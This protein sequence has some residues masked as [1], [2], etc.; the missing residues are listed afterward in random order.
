M[1]SPVWSTTAGLLAVINEREFYSQTLTATDADGDTLTYSKIAGTL[2][3]GIELTSGG[4]L[5]GTPSEVST[6]T[7]Y[8]FVI[9]ASDGTNIAD[10]TF[11]LQVQ[12][13]DIPVFTTA[14][15]QIDMQDSTQ[16]RVN[17]WVLDGSFINF[18][19]VATDTDTAAG[20]SLTYFLQSGE[21]PPGIELTSDGRI[22]GTV[23]LTD[24]ERYGPIGGYDNY[25]K[26]DD[27]GYDPTAFSTSISKNFEFEVET[28]NS[29][30]EL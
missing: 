16:G 14:A 23:L 3:T 18:Q 12:G 9:R 10:R 17:K 4:V 25:Y 2:P 20:Q 26:Y 29:K 24:D 30:F 15:G 13:A 11:S 8:T 6:R 21:L 7:L 1:A 19:L 22:T 27:V 5:R 28:S